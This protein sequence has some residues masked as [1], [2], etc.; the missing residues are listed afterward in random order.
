MTLIA[1]TREA[2]RYSQ[3]VPYLGV[4][5][6][7]AS[8]TIACLRRDR[9]NP[10]RRVDIPSLSRRMIGAVGRKIDRLMAATGV[11]LMLGPTIAA[12]ADEC[13]PPAEVD[14]RPGTPQ[15]ATTRN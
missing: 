4:P 10:Y 13:I 7:R 1:A 12:A 9:G 3:E 15:G 8:L 2:A 6:Y 5:D 14:C 11:V